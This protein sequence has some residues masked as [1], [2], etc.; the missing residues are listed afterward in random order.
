MRYATFS[1]AH[2]HSLETLSFVFL[3]SVY[4][5]S[6]LLYIHLSNYPSFC[7][8]TCLAIFLVSIFILPLLSLITWLFKSYIL[9]NVFTIRSTFF[10]NYQSL[11][12]P[13]LLSASLFPLAP[14]FREKIQSE[15]KRLSCIQLSS[16]FVYAKPAFFYFFSSYIFILFFFCLFY[17]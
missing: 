1:L 10:S 12:F 6:S 15:C 13:I 9:I 17:N 8:P 3:Q 14:D 5:S 4:L 11:S 16:T 7:V 2:F